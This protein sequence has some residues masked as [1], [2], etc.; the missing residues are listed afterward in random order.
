LSPRLRSQTL[1]RICSG[2]VLPAT[3]LLFLMSLFWRGSTTYAFELHTE[4]IAFST[5]DSR[6]N[7]WVVD[8]GRVED[9][10]GTDTVFYGALELADSVLVRITRVGTGELSVSLRAQGKRTSVGLYR[11]Q[12]DSI[13]GAAPDEVLI[14]Y[15]DMIARMDSGRSVVF[16]F[17]GTLSEPDSPDGEREASLPVL[18]SGEVILLTKSFLS[19]SVYPAATH[20]LALGDQVTVRSPK[21]AVVGVLVANEDPALAVSY[22]VIAGS[23]SIQRPVYGEYRLTTTVAQRIGGDAALQAAWW[24]VAFLWAVR[25]WLQIKIF[26]RKEND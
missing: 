3:F 8:G 17:T 15:P 16:S 21:S 23:V 4:I 11:T 7:I 25:S 19:R 10:K 20:P 1:L 2:A 26:F 12:A 14:T 24:T 9:S 18:R 5:A 13:A 22:R 6:K